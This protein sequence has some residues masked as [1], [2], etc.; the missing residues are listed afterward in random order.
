MKQAG[1]GHRQGWRFRVVLPENSPPNRYVDV[2]KHYVEHLQDY[3]ALRQTTYQRY[4]K[5]LNWSALG[6]VFEGI[7]RQLV[8]TNLINC[9]LNLTE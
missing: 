1:W 7:I 2:V 4:Q 8:K 3:Q 6:Q 9:A 5:E